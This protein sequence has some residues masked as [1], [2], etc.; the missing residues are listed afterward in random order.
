MERHYQPDLPPVSGD[1]HRLE[2]AALNVMLNAVESME[3]GGRLTIRLFTH[4]DRVVAEF[5]DTGPGIPP[6]EVE[7]V[8]LPFYSTKP[9]GTGLGLPLVTRVVAAHD[10]TLDIRSEPGRGTTVRMAFP[11]RAEAADVGAAGKGADREGPEA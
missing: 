1:G 2:Q 7:K 10:G 8:L 3:H 9:A 6:G 5:E 11:V 4:E